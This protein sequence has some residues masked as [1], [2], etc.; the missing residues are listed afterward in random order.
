MSRCV[1]NWDLDHGHDGDAPAASRPRVSFLCPDVSSVDCEVAELTWENGQLSL[2]GL[3]Q[4]RLNSKPA[5]TAGTLE[6]LMDQ[7]AAAT[8]AVE[9]AVPIGGCKPSFACG[10]GLVP[11]FDPSQDPRDVVGAASANMMM[12]ALVPCA[13]AA[14]DDPCRQ[15]M[16][17]LADSAA[18]GTG[19]CGCCSAC[20]GSCSAMGSGDRMLHPVEDERQEGRRKRTCFDVGCGEWGDRQSMS[21]SGTFSRRVTTLDT[22][23][24]EEELE[25][26]PSEGSLE[27]TSSGKC[28][29]GRAAPATTEEHDTVYSRPQREEEWTR[30]NGKSSLSTKR[31]RAAAIHNQSERKRRDKINQRMKT[32]QKLVP[33]S[34]K[35][36]K[37]SVLDEVI[38]YLKHL[39]AQVQLMSRTSMMPMILPLA[40]QQLQ[41]SM[42]AA[43]G[44]GLGLAGMPRVMVGDMSA[45]GVT[46]RSNIPVIPPVPSLHPYPFMP[47]ASWD[48][49]LSGLFTPTASVPHP[50][51]PDPLSAFFA[52]Q[53]VP[54]YDVQAMTVDAYTRLAA[55]YQQQQQQQH[56]PPNPNN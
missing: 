56:R 26:T 23:E 13:T 5:A 19:A 4:P 16:W 9:H 18:H 37:A 54:D 39:Q 42:M 10:A 51:P 55:L 8:V 22:C 48:S 29:G 43:Q 53:S 12:D 2:H 24:Q 49:V 15:A 38:D 33:N 36:D 7:A 6:S 46:A 44:L 14:A 35:T 30:R 20:V 27:N 28:S 3:G 41:L 32:L 11:W 1:P 45:L 34:S 21:G 47:T 52:R 50:S 31:R 25:N 17:L 40:L